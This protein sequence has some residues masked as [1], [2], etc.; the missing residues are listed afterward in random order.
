MRKYIDISRPT[1][2]VN[3]NKSNQSWIVFRLGEIYLNTA[4]AAYELG[5]KTVALD[6]VEKIRL[7][8]GCQITRPALDQSVKNTYGYPI[9]ASLQF[10]RDERTRELYC[11]NHYWW[12]LRTWR[13]AD[14]VLYNQTP[15]GLSCYY[16]FDEGKYI[17]IEEI[18]RD[19]RTITAPKS[20]VYEMIPQSEINKNTNLLP[21]NP[22]Y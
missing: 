5:N 15:H 7:R 18:N 9:E 4:E 22:L 12:D 2:L 14:Q 21:Q 13:I 10:I 17:Y 8:A 11:E 19:N 20:V 16:V 6:Y 3:V 1:A